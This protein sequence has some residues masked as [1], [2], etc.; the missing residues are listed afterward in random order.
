M[1][2]VDE[3]PPRGATTGTTMMPLVKEL[4]SN[5]GKWAKISEHETISTASARAVYLKRRYGLDAV[6][7]TNRETG[8]HDVYA[9]WPEDK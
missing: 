1:E 5:P 7:R 6:T 9:R 2:F 3:P 4:Q 8:K